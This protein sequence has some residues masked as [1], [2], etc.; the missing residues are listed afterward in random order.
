MSLKIYKKFYTLGTT[1]ENDCR[2]DLCKKI[3]K[4]GVMF[5]TNKTQYKSQ[6]WDVTETVFSLALP[7]PPH[8]PFL[9]FPLL[10]AH[11]HTPG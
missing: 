10:H 3:M 9:S 8:P 2:Q 1:N 11:T 4:M 7:R 5:G 6:C